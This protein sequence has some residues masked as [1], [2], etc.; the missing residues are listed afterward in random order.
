MDK[1]RIFCNNVQTN[2]YYSKSHEGD[3][4]SLAL[5]REFIG[6]LTQILFDEP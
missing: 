3:D 4:K 5:S 6:A 2:E 1:E